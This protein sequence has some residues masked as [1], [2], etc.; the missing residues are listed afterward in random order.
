MK[1]YTDRSPTIHVM[2]TEPSG[3]FFKPFFIT[4]SA[5]NQE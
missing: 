4:G 2:N 1:T 3:A 5:E